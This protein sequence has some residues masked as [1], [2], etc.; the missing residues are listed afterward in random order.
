MNPETEIKVD[1]NLMQEKN[2]TN[3]VQQPQVNENDQEDLKEI[4]WKKFKEARQKDR[5]HAELMTKIAAEK[6]AEALALKAAMEAIL[7][8]PSNNNQNYNNN[9]FDEDESEEDIIEKKVMLALAKREQEAE[10]IRK[11]KEHQEF[12]QRL[13]STYPDFN[14][15]CNTNNLDYL[16]YHFPEVAEA[17]KHV[18]D[19]YNKWQAVY[20]AVKRFVPTIDLKKEQSKM[21]NNLLKPQSISSASVSPEGSQLAPHKLTEQRRQENWA[22]MQKQLKGLS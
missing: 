19:G 17:F 15:V 4:N 10:K 2:D 11:E 21:N 18:P 13:V 6:E 1:T 8:K 20:K 7:N 12:P 3:L 16:E 22:R 14:Q 5:D 9:G